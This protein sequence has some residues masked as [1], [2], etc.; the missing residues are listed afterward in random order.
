MPGNS[1]K[2][3]LLALSPLEEEISE[4]LE[5]HVIKPD[6]LYFLNSLPSP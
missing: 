5:Q 3:E 4:N 2:G 6:N 1:Y